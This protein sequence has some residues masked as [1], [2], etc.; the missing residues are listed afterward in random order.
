[1]ATKAKQAELDKALWEACADLYLKD[2]M[3]ITITVMNR[4]KKLV[5]KGANPLYR[6]KDKEASDGCRP[7]PLF[8]V[9]ST[10]SRE[11]AELAEFMSGIGPE[12][13]EDCDLDDMEEVAL[14]NLK[15]ALKMVHALGKD[16]FETIKF[17]CDMLEKSDDEDESDE[18][19]S[20]DHEDES[21]D[22]ESSL[23][24]EKEKLAAARIAATLLAT[25]APASAP[26]AKRPRK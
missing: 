10:N 12:D 25:D 17:A 5:K 21:D 15:T 22:E 20:D 1:M 2:Q 9:V 7:S 23:D 14:R 19:E 13:D 26:A 18:D 6:H 16:K 3:S 4:I 8:C 24:E 11:G